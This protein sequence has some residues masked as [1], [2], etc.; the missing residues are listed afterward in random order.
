MLL[1][2]GFGR[3][4]GQVLSIGCLWLLLLQMVTLL[5]C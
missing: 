4:A 3:E 2:R 1:K 5:A